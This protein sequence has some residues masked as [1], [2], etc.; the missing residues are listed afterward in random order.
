MMLHFKAP[1]HDIFIYGDT[2]LYRIDA[3]ARRRESES[4]TP[5]WLYTYVYQRRH[6]VMFFIDE[7]RQS[8]EAIY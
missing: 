4:L 8:H 7:L 6:S 2:F 5:Q 1:R 3:F